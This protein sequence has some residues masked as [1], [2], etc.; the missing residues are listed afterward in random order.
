MAVIHFINSKKAQTAVGMKAVLNYTMQEKKTVA[1]GK[2]FVSGVN[3]MAETSLAEFQNTK[4]LFH[5]ETGRQYYHFVQSFAPGEA[6]TPEL[7]HEIALQFASECEKLK[8]FEIVVSTHCDRDHIHSHFVMNSVNSETGKKFHISEREINLLM[9]E[10]DQI[11]QQYGLAVVSPQP[12]Q[13]KNALSA[14]E[15]RSAYKG[16]SWKS[17]LMVAID[18]AMCYADNRPEFIDLMERQGYQVKW[19]RDR[20]YITYTTPEGFKCRDNKL[21]EDKYLKSNMQAEFRIRVDVFEDIVETGWERERRRYFESVFE[22]EETPVVDIE[23]EFA[24][25][26]PIGVEAGFLVADLSN[27]IDEDRKIEDSTTMRRPR[28]QKKNEQDYGPVI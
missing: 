5:K 14:R 19:T 22:D 28:K 23:A 26:P 11:I 12:K 9:Q 2:K 13:K 10:S 18:K 17:R 6:V 25:P 8:G 20:K 4:R 3:C 16:Q 1:D 24:D 7:A 27:I 15:Y 21:H